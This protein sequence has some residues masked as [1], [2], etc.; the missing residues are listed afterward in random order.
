MT[1][2]TLITSLS[3]LI[4]GSLLLQSE[5]SSLDARI[6]EVVQREILA[7]G[8]PSV[9][10]A[11]MRDG[12]MLLQRAWGVSDIGTGA[13]ADA[14]TTYQIA[15]SSKQFTAALVLKQVERG[16]I[17]LTDA[18]GRHLTGL[19]PEFTAI[20]I[21]QLL[22]HTSGLPAD[23]RSPARSGED[24][25]A[26]EL[27]KMATATSLANEP[28][29]TFVYSNTG[30]FLLAVL[31]E[32]LYGKSFAAAL[33]D[34]IAKPLGLT[35]ARCGPGKPGES[36]G[37]RLLPDGKVVPPPGL[38]HSQLLGAGGICATAGDLVR[39][40]H[41]LHTGRV[42]GPTTYA[43]MTTPRGVAAANNY[44]LGQYVRPA[45]W[46]GK[47]ITH[48]G[49]ST[50]GHTSELQ[51]YVDGSIAYAMLYNAGPRTP[52][53]SDLIPRVVMGVPL[54]EKSK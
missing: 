43:A 7:R 19:K 25:S 14:S 51:W 54:P 8:V 44:G 36:A 4:T 30:Y 28:G 32:K 47:V 22:N 45:P 16:K 49:T 52:G 20:T 29:T 1:T 18:V 38:H 41:A 50:T 42:L 9:S 12:K 23:Y 21:E 53:I 34:E 11:V 10:V 27:F 26:D 39:W 17:A 6:D 46:G 40:T 31:V 15:S 3:L 5:P 35:L 37:Y 24:I 33:Q 48:G 13:R 2:T